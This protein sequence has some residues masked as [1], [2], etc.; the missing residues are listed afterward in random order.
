MSEL[1]PCPF[2]GGSAYRQREVGNI[3]VVCHE[4][5]TIALES[6]WNQRTQPS[7]SESGGEGK[8]QRWVIE[9]DPSR[10]REYGS[11]KFGRTPQESHI[12]GWYV[13]AGWTEALRIETPWD[14][15]PLA[16]WRTTIPS[17]DGMEADDD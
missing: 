17:A 6:L 3:F 10:V 2:C 13:E 11:I 4:C 7:A 12:T 16:P 15:E 1:K 8:T 14:I 9:I 5:G